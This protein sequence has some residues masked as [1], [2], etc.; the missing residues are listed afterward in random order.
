MHVGSKGKFIIPSKLAY[1]PGGQGGV[2]PPYSTLL[3]DVE[4]VNIK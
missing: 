3:F 1:G 2:I 4:L